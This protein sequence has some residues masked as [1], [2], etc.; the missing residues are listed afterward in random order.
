MFEYLIWKQPKT[1]IEFIQNQGIEAFNELL[2][3]ATASFMFEIKQL[4][5]RFDLSDP[6]YK[7]RFSD[8]VAKKLLTIEGKIERDNYLEAIVAEYKNVKKMDYMNLWPSMGIMWGLLSESQM[9]YQ[10]S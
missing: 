2:K 6:E 7:T 10:K 5:K 1:R 4:S 3:H 9:C 8:E